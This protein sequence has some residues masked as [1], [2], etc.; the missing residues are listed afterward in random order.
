MNRDLSFYICDDRNIFSFQNIVFEETPGHWTESKIMVMFITKLQQNL[1][2][3]E[4][5]CRNAILY[6]SVPWLMLSVPYFS[7][8][9]LLC[10]RQVQALS[11]LYK[12]VS[13]SMVVFVIF[14]DGF[15]RDEIKMTLF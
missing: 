12:M 10:R 14:P 5:C 3:D 11:M 15:N 9:V 2:L 8:T 4:K 13:I 7:Y 6:D 1:K